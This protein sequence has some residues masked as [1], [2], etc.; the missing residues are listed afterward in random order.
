MQAVMVSGLAIGTPDCWTR[1][2]AL[3]LGLRPSKKALNGVILLGRCA[4]GGVVGAA[5][6]LMAGNGAFWIGLGLALGVGLNALA[7][8]FGTPDGRD[9]PGGQEAPSGTSLPYRVR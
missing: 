7:S 4:M 2:P 9:A 1:L 8:R 5:F 6:A 3:R